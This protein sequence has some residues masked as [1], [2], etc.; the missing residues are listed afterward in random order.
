MLMPRLLCIVD[1][2]ARTFR[3]Q[4]SAH[5]QRQSDDVAERISDVFGTENIIRI[6]ETFVGCY[7][8][9]KTLAWQKLSHGIPGTPL[10]K[11][12]YPGVDAISSALPACDSQRGKHSNT[13][14]ISDVFGTENITR[15]TETFV[16]CYTYPTA[17]A[18]QKL[19]HGIPSTAVCSYFYPGVGAISSA[20]PACDSQRAKHSNTER[21]SDVFGTEN[22]S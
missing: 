12:R 4:I 14:R 1:G 19:S 17:L 15:I 5:N 6:T 20:L 10:L 3:T 22:I 2:M 9:P 11:H 16:G 7:T 21:I 13:E 18:W 8:Y